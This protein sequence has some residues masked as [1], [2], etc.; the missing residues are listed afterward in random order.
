[1]VDSN[2]EPMVQVSDC[3]VSIVRKYF[4]FLEMDEDG[5]IKTIEAFD[6]YQMANLK[7]LNLILGLSSTANNR[8][9]IQICCGSLAEKMRRIVRAYVP[10]SDDEYADLLKCRPTE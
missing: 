3:I 4:L 5:V 2:D 1:M 6:K 7:L 9:H 10:E 8:L